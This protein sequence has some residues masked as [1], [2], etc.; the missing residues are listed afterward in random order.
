MAPALEVQ[1]GETVSQNNV[2][3]SVNDVINR[4]KVT[5]I[6]SG[7]W[8]SVASKLIASNTLRLNNFHGNI[9]LYIYHLSSLEVFLLEY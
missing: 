3:N 4:S 6:G 2:L 7:N 8:G 5:V 1:G 9:L